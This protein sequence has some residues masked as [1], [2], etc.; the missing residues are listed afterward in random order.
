MEG[1]ERETDRRTDGQTDRQT[2]RQTDG[3][4]D[5]RT[6]GQTDRQTDRQTEDLTSPLL[7]VLLS[8]ERS[9]ELTSPPRAP[10]T[11]EANIIHVSVQKPAHS[12]RSSLKTRATITMLMSEKLSTSD[13]SGSRKS[14]ISPMVP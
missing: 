2:D 1:R 4:T 7:A 8:T 10:D 9:P 13:S 14:S 6:D 5:G 12:T 3:R 11:T